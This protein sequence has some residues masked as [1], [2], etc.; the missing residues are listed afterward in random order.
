MECF[1]LLPV[2][3]RCRGQGLQ[4]FTLR[5][6]CSGGDAGVALGGDGS[7]D[8][9]AGVVC[10][11]AAQRF[12][13]VEDTDQHGVS[14]P[15]DSGGKLLFVF[16]YQ[17]SQRSGGFGDLVVLVSSNGRQIRK[18]RPNTQRKRTGREIFF[19]ILQIDA[20][21]RNEPAVGKRRTECLDVTGPAAAATGENLDDVRAQ[22]P[23]SH[24]LAGSKRTGYG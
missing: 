19:G 13:I 11:G 17:S 7:T 23:G 14:S 16:P 12:P 6:R 20:A 21:C 4:K 24:H 1:N 15:L 18:L 8:N 9:L 5:S 22:F 10:G 3:S 2:N